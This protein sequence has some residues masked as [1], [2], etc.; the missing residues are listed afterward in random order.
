M[1][2]VFLSG[3]AKLPDNTTAQKLYNHLVLVVTA[4]VPDGTILDADCTM[5]TELGRRFI[6]ELLVGY[7]LRRGPEPLAELL[8][9]SYYGHL[10]KAL[11]TCIK[12]IC[13]QFGE[14]ARGSQSPKSPG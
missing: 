3:Y 2:K 8:S 9:Q 11:Q 6:R 7:D 4:E 1:R 14:L 5:A 13:L 10:R 12:G